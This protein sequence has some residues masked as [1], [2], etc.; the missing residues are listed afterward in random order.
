[1]RP[2]GIEFIL[3]IQDE[4]DFC[5]QQLTD[6]TFESFV[7][8]AVLSRAVVRSL[9]IIGEA[10]KNVPAEFR[11]KYP[12]IEWKMMAGM[13]DRLIHHYFGI[14]YETVYNTVKNDLPQLKEWID[15]LL[16]TEN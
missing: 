11:N 9:E 7:N 10:G 16:K 1:M 8:D 12:M 13:R 14:D 15:I 5:L 4:V 2:S 3:H 6:K